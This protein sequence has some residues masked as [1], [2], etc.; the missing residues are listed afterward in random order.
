[1]KIHELK[2]KAHT[3][4][5]SWGPVLSGDIIKACEE[6]IDLIEGLEDILNLILGDVTV[7]G[8]T[9]DEIS[10]SIEELTEKALAKISEVR[11]DRAVRSVPRAPAGF[12]EDPTEHLIDEVEVAYAQWLRQMKEI[13]K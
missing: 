1:M 8:A 13:G 9:E 6:A 11:E 7:C 3:H 2:E 12:K 10:K 5:L 4:N